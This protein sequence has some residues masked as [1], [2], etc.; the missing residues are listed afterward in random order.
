MNGIT[1][2]P[3]QHGNWC[4]YF[5][6]AVDRWCVLRKSNRTCQVLCL[7]LDEGAWMHLTREQVN[8]LLPHLLH[9]VETG[10]LGEKGASV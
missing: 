8:D 4:G 7:G 10:R 3:D 6:D 5:K 9:F 1:W 2:H